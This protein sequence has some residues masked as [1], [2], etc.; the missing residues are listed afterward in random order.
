MIIIYTLGGIFG[1][2]FG[3]LIALFIIT[4]PEKRFDLTE[5]SYEL[6]NQNNEKTTRTTEKERD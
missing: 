4:R 3:L 2:T 1:F 6:K 5:E